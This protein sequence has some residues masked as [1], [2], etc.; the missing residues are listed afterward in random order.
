VN[1][2]DG[3][4]STLKVAVSLRD[5]ARAEAVPS[6]E[7]RTLTPTLVQAMWESGLM[8]AMNPFEAGGSEPDFSDMIETWIEM[9]W[10]DGSFGWVGIANF[11]SSVAA[12]AYLPAKGRS[13]K[14]GTGCP[15]P[16]TS[17]PEPGTRRMWPP[18]SSPWR[19]APPGW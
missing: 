18:G 13:S 4:S 16:G 7:L 10:Q 3:R 8:I 9:A 6:E 11:P 15:A 17:A 1:D 19:A 2:L 14:A 5:L 12:A